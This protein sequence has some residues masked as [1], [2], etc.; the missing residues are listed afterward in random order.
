MRCWAKETVFFILG[1]LTMITVDSIAFI[2]IYITFRYGSEALSTCTVAGPNNEDSSTGDQPWNS[3]S[4]DLPRLKRLHNLNI[5]SPISDKSGDQ[6]CFSS[7]IEIFQYIFLY[8]K[9]ILLISLHIKIFI[10]LKMTEL[11]DEL[12]ICM[13]FKLLNNS[14][15]YSIK[16]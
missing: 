12:E 4:G 5:L 16:F 11:K 8:S 15:V 7:P 10:F 14:K 13:Y 6:E 3:G 9:Y 1:T 2:N